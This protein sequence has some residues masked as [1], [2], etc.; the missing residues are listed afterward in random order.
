L[1]EPLSV[2]HTAAVAVGGFGF[3][4]THQPFAKRIFA[5]I[6]IVPSMLE[7][8]AGHPHVSEQRMERPLA[9]NVDDVSTVC[10]GG[11][12]NNGAETTNT[13]KSITTILRPFI[14][15]PPSPC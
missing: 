13:R 8:Q 4:Q 9:Y 10:S 11:A 5:H 7:T 15:P 2:V 3:A 6:D 14:K 1:H 12:A